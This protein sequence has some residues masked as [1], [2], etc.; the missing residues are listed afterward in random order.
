MCRI[1]VQHNFRTAAKG[2]EFIDKVTTKFTKDIVK[3]VVRLLKAIK[4]EEAS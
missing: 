1:N 4:N 2:N 3:Y